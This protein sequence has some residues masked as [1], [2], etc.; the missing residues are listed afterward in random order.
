MKIGYERWT[1][2]WRWD[3]AGEY[4]DGDDDPNYEQS[5]DD[6]HGFDF[7]L[8]EGNLPTRITLP[9]WKVLRESLASQTEAETPEVFYV[10]F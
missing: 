5:V 6:D 9:E 8:S 1:R 4:V 3:G 2:V 7:P 10:F